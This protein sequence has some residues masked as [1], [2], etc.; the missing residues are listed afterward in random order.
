MADFLLLLLLN[1]F[2]TLIYIILTASARNYLFVLIMCAAVTVRLAFFPAAAIRQVLSETAG[3]VMISVF[4]LLP[5]V[6]MGN[7]QTLANITAGCMYR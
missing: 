5:A 1:Y 4:L 3:A 7:P 6:F 2:Y